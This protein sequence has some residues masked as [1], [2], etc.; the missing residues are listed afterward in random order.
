[1]PT[2]DL[3]FRRRLRYGSLASLLLVALAACS[4]NESPPSPPSALAIVSGD[5]QYTRKGTK[6]EEP[7]VVRV[8]DDKGNPA[9]GMT[10]HFQVV[11]GGGSL[12]R[13]AATTNHDGRTSVSWTLGP[14]TGL[15]RM[16]IT[17]AENSALGATAT[18]TS[19]EYYCVEEDPT[20]SAKFGGAGDLMMLTHSTSL[21]AGAGLVHYDIN[22]STLSFAGSLLQGFPDNTGQV[23]VRDCVCASRA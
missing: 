12:S 10:V 2:S 6:L 1:M 14:N 16:R 3:R 23:T 8:A 21:S 9:A 11:E 13:A 4:N 7:L 19:S 15:N 5:A 22:G 18:A 20:F 17:V